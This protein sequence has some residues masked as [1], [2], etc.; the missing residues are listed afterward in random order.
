MLAYMNA[1]AHLTAM[2]DLT[3]TNAINIC[4]STGPW[5]S[6]L[7]TAAKAIMLVPVLTTARATA[8]LPP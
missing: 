3:T 4:Y 1:T 2:L 5:L 6:H 8:A 7:F